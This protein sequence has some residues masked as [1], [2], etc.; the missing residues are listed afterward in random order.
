VTHELPDEAWDYA[1]RPPPAWAWSI[2]PDFDPNRPAAPLLERDFPAAAKAALAFLKDLGFVLTAADAWDVSPSAMTVV[3]ERSD[4]VVLATLADDGSFYALI[5]PRADDAPDTPARDRLSAFIG[6]RDRVVGF[7]SLPVLGPTPVD[8]ATTVADYAAVLRSRTEALLADR[9]VDFEKLAEAV[10]QAIEDIRRPRLVAYYTERAEAAWGGARYEAFLDAVRALDEVGSPLADPERVA[11]AEA[12]SRPTLTLGRSDLPETDR[13]R[14]AAE[15]VEETQQRLNAAVEQRHTSREA[16][17]RWE[18]AAHEWHEA[19][20]LLYPAD[21]WDG[22][23]R[24]RNGE[25]DAIEPAITFLEVDPWVFRSGYAKET[26]LRFLK[27]TDLDDE[28]AA[29]L[30]RVI[31]AAVDAGDRREFRGYCRLARR[32]VDD[33]LRLALLERLRSSDRGRARRALWVLDALVESLGPDDRAAAQRLLE[34]AATDPDWWRVSSWVRAF[35]GRY[36][37]Q[38][39]VD[40]LLERAVGGGRDSGTALRLLSGVR[41]QPTAEQR[42]T[43]GSLVLRQIERGDDED[44]LEST[45]ALADSP[46]FREQLVEA[47]RTAIEPDERRRAWWAIN[48]IRRTARDGW[49]PEDFAS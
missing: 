31:L 24:L 19:M 48:A 18:D 38:S 2:E 39:W 28:Q 16:Q 47:Y 12:R 14:R 8:V 40:G 29:R 27:R 10:E 20:A 32:V 13:I 37:D 30:R 34:L 49:P 21:F 15:L 11:I 44:W 7:G 1:F 9:P 42:R 26:I 3:W 4:A 41:I 23:E 45:A 22:I 36:A 6:D 33:D 35:M 46:A 5:G 17:A 43:L 25:R